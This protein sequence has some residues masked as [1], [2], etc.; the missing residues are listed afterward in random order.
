MA[1]VRVIVGAGGADSGVVGG[2]FGGTVTLYHRHAR[3]HRRC[4]HRRHRP[5]LWQQSC[6]VCLLRLPSGVLL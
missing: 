3:R 5:G 4:Q 6:P 1:D 2:F